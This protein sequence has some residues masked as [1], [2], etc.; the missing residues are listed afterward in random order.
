[1]DRQSLES[2]FSAFNLTVNADDYTMPD[3]DQITKDTSEPRLIYRIG[4][5][6][7]DVIFSFADVTGTG[8]KIAASVQA[9]T[10][11]GGIGISQ[12]VYEVVRSYLPLQPIEIGRWQFEG[13]EEPMRLYQLSL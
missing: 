1:V 4:I 10:S 5:H 12:T 2:Y 11:P 3:F 8:V 13:L 6:C 7:G 9:E